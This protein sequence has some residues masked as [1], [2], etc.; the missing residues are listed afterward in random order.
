M[1]E[2][3]SITEATLRELL[4][5]GAVRAVQIVGQGTGWAVQVE[6]GMRRRTLRSAR[7]PVR[8]WRSL[9]RLA[10][11]LRD[12]L[13]IAEWSVDARQYQPGQR[14]ARNV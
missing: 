9:D 14:N 5:S 4:D 2:S 7:E 3:K 13:G 12:D 10:R 8:W 11:W 6:V 1:S